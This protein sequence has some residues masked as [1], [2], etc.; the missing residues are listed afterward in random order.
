MTPVTQKSIEQLLSDLYRQEVKLWVEGDQLKCRAPEA[1]LTETLSQELQARKAELVEFLTQANQ[2]QTSPSAQAPPLKPAPRTEELPL[3]FAQQ[4]LWFLEQMPQAG[5][6]YNIPMAVQ[7]QGDLDLAA[8]TAS[9][10]AII[11]RHEALRTNFIAVDGQPQQVIAANRILTPQQHDL[12]SVDSAEHEAQVQ[13]LAREEAQTPFDL[14]QDLLLRVTLIH[15][16]PTEAVVLFTVHHIVADGWS[17]AVLLQEL[18]LFYRVALDDSQPPLPPLL[19]QY[20][21]FAIWQRQWLQG[22]VLAQ[23]LD[24]WRTQLAQPLPVLQL[25]TDFPR[26]RVQSFRGAVVNFALT[27]ELTQQIRDLG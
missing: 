18:Q 4:R 26:A 14:T 16:A 6:I 15:L 17:M 3:S 5:A 1:V 10:N 9:L 22:E 2:A 13:Q 7:V 21:D 23:Q 19:I 27:P 12:Q 20:A 25:P 24:F 8:F 11:D